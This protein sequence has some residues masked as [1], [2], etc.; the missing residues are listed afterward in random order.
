[1]N[2]AHYKNY[3]AIV[4]FVQRHKEVFPQEARDTTRPKEI[5]KETKRLPRKE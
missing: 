5:P 2:P 3:K 1:L 4:K